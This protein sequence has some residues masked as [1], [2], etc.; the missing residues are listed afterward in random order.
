MEQNQKAIKD[1]GKTQDP[2]TNI[3][4]QRS[5]LTQSIRH[6][7]QALVA[8]Q[9]RQNQLDIEQE[10]L[11][12][13]LGKLETEG[14]LI[15]FKYEVYEAQLEDFNGVLD[16]FEQLG[17]DESDAKIEQHINAIH[18]KMD[19]ILLQVDELI[20]NNQDE[21]AAI[22]MKTH[23]A[24][25]LKLASH[26]DML[27]VRKGD[28]YYL[29]AD[30]NEVK[31]HKD[32]HFI[33]ETNL[34]TTNET[35]MKF[36]PELRRSRIYKDENNK[37]YLLKPGQTWDSIKEDPAAK[38]EA[39]KGFE[40]NKQELMVVKNVIHHNKKMET[41]V[42][43]DQVDN[44]KESIESKKAEK[45][46]LVN[47]KNTIESS[48]AQAR[49]MSKQ[50]DSTNTV[51]L[52]KPIPSPS[53]TGSSKAPQ[54]GGK[55]PAAVQAYRVQLETLFNQKKGDIT[56]G[57][58]VTLGALPPDP[59]ARNYVLTQ[60]A[61]MPRNAPIPFQTM[62]SLLRNLERFGVDT[63]KPS[64]TTIKSEAKVRRE[65]EQKEERDSPTPFSTNPFKT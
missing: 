58:L 6:Y 19:N 21:D 27:A 20:E 51:N 37:Y 41:E 13:Q 44:V 26:H 9:E 54:P 1:S 22:L 42:H 31:S 46:L 53:I 23:T 12:K 25:N 63:T 28:K 33:L 59:T 40:N 62:Q 8:N 35:L 4:S 50:L 57:Q 3:E 61:N 30:G 16:E 7:E 56:P 43:K 29:D 65:T 52:T 17:P 18:T 14:E 60:L 11:Q 47:Q 45:L 48:L 36:P 24:L 15:G 34:N 2:T 5:S 32:A 39:N 64:V 38:E 55:A 49:E 10:V